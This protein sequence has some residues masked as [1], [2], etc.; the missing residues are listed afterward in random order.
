MGN[1]IERSKHTPQTE[2]EMMNQH[3]VHDEVKEEEEEVEVQ[4]GKRENMKIKILLTKEEL[5]WLMFELENRQGKGLEDVLGEI[6]RNRAKSASVW[7]PSLDSIIECP[8]EHYG[9]IQD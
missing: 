2:T 8:E 6:Q 9:K 5:E 7:K 3:H 4:K 1:C